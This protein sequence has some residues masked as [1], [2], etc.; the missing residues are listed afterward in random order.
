VDAC[1]ASPSK[2][3]RLAQEL[4]RLGLAVRAKHAV[5]WTVG[6]GDVTGE[7]D[8]VLV[9]APCTGVGTLRHRPEIALRLKEEDVA[10]KA[11]AQLAIAS[12][13]ADRV[14]PGGSLVYVVCSVLREEGEDVV[15]A[16]LAARPELRAAAFDAPV[17]TALFGQATS[18]RLLPHVHGTDGY[19]VARMVRRGAGD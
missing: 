4:K 3:D 1:D 13:I 5:D 17:V 12:T 9:D 16:L 19:F 10:I 18:F 7:Y 2:L 14:K 15:E 8:R 6:P 11:R